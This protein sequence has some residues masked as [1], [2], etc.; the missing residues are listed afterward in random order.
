M[1]SQ[2]HQNEEDVDRSLD[3]DAV[4]RELVM[5]D[6]SL[7]VQFEKRDE[8]VAKPAK[9]DEPKADEAE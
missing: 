8:K 2:P 3:L 4:R 7:A 6:P 5:R 9:A 1:E